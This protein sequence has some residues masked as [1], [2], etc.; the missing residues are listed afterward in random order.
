MILDLHILKRCRCDAVFFVVKNSFA[1]AF[2]ARAFAPPAGLA[3]GCMAGFA[4]HGSSIGGHVPMN[5][6][7][8]LNSLPHVKCAA[9]D[10]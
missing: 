10:R 1:Q 9:T 7:L 4:I 3:R 8:C 5:N 6:D 2:I